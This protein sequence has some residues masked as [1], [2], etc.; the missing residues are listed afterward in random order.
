MRPLLCALACLAVL[1]L[2]SPTQGVSISLQD[3]F[4][5]ELLDMTKWQ[6]ITPDRPS[7]NLVLQRDDFNDNALDAAKW[8]V[9]PTLP[10]W[11]G[12]VAEQN[13]R[14]E[15]DSRAH[16][17]TASQYDPVTSV[18]LRI[19]GLWSQPTDDFMQILTRSNGTPTGTYGETGSGIEFFYRFNYPVSGQGTINL[20]GR[21]GASVA[22][23]VTENHLSIGHHEQFEFTIVDDGQNVSLFVRDLADPDSY[24]WAKAQCTTDMAT[25]YVAFHNRESSGTRI[26]YLDDVLIARAPVLERNDQAELYG[27]GHLVTRDE[28][29]PLTVGGMGLQITG[30]WTFGPGGDFMQILTRSDGVPSGTYGET[31]RGVEFLVSEATDAIDI[32]GRGAA[33]G[34]KTIVNNLSVA[35]GDSFSFEIIDT[36]QEL[37]FLVQEIGDPDSWGYGFATCSTDMAT[38]YIVFHNREGNRYSYLDDVSIRVYPEPA[39]LA[40]LGAGLV[41]LLRRRRRT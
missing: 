35:A 33:V 34:N 26:S 2:A 30:T 31:Q 16:L 20:S 24:A 40:L 3:D 19:T 39:T 38:D 25:D 41:A 10:P 8:T 9:A 15:I 13:Q 12:S 6:V 17:N 32:T 21:G 7:A 11:N 37:R 22:N 29:D 27:R 28:Y 23:K 5:D 14:A 1:T 4:N 36:G 18:P